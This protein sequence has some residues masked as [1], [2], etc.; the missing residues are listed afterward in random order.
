M[1]NDECIWEFSKFNLILPF[2]DLNNEQSNLN[3]FF[4]NFNWGKSS[5]IPFFFFFFFLNH[6]L[7]GIPWKNWYTIEKHNMLLDVHIIRCT[8]H[9]NLKPPLLQPHVLI[10][11]PKSTLHFRRT[12]AYNFSLKHTHWRI[13]YFWNHSLEHKQH[14]LESHQDLKLNNVK[15]EKIMNTITLKNNLKSWNRKIPLFCFMKKEGFCVQQVF[16][17]FSIP[18]HACI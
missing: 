11:A 3:S 16:S 4:Y 17:H 2:K 7:N 5:F 6:K 13:F 12:L 18:L 8:I 9:E 14:M 10:K 1:D 15:D